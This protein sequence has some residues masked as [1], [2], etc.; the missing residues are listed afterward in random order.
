VAVLLPATTFFLGKETYAP[1]RALVEDGV[2]LALATD[3]NPGTSM[4]ES[5]PLIMTMG[6]TLFKMVAEEVIMAV[7]VHGAKSLGREDTI[8]TLKAGKRA[9]VVVLDIPNYRYLP[10]HLASTT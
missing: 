5:L 6:C 8:G 4:T 7:T 9:D 3:F 2:P 10:Y 1:A